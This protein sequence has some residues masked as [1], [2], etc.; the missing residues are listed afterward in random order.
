MQKPGFS[1]IAAGWLIYTPSSHLAVTIAVI[2]NLRSV[3][4]VWHM[5]C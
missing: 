5:Y 4:S 3:I 1:C 2:V